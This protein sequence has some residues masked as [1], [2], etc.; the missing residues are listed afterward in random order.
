MLWLLY[1]IVE[2]AAYYAEGGKTLYE[3]MEDMYGEYGGFADETV[4]I[5][6]EGFD[7]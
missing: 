2:M 7:G 5:T 3:V 6:M 4:S 1:V